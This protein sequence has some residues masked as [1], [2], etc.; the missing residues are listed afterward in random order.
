MATSGQLTHNG[1]SDILRPSIWFPPFLRAAGV[2]VVWAHD[3]SGLPRS[4][5]A[6]QQ[7]AQAITDGRGVQKPLAQLLGLPLHQLPAVKARSASRPPGRD[8]LLGPI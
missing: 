8:A 3:P 6:V 4:S 5:P 1:Q 2:F 7:G